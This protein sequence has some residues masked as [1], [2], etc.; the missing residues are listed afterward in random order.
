MKVF[1]SQPMAGIPDEKVKAKR[2]E[3]CEKLKEMHIEVISSFI[4][5]D[6]HE[7]NHLPVY[8]LGRSIQ[9]MAEADAVL[10]VDG[11]LD[12]RGCMLEHKICEVYGIKILYEDFIDPQYDSA[13]CVSTMRG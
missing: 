10:F 2:D 5:G 1:I 4:E 7:S 13:C 6:N 9:M 8:Y 3:I 12:A 11:W